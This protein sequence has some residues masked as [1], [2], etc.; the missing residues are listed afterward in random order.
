MGWWNA[1][2]VAIAGG[3]KKLQVIQCSFQNKGWKFLRGLS[4]TI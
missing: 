2:E 3:A 4:L 1:S